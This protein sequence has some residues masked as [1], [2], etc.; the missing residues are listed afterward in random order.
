MDSVKV[1]PLNSLRFLQ[2]GIKTVISDWRM[3]QSKRRLMSR[4]RLSSLIKPNLRNPIF[5]VGA[6]RSGTTFLGSCFS[7]IPEISYHFEPILIKAASRYV[8]ED[9]WDLSTAK[10]FY[11]TVYS[12][13]M[14]LHCDADL[15]FAEKTP[16][17]SFLISFLSTTFPDAQFIHIIRD[18]RDA[19]LSY[20]KKPWLQ[21]ASAL[22]KK[23]DEAGGYP[24]GPYAR[25]WVE[26]DRIKEFETTSDI[27]RCIWAWRRHT[28]SVL[29]AASQLPAKQYHELRYEKLALNSVEEAERLLNFL[30]IF[31]SQSRCIFK[32]ATARVKAD[33]V[34]RWKHELS[35]E[36]LLSIEKEAGDLLSN[37]GYVD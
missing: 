26:S 34:G 32:Q 29:S 28:E 33:S 21:A 2:L 30:G 18:G 9:L 4:E 20:S 7:K 22:S 8:Y 15:R 37:L 24:Y 31:E 1:K 6:P 16:R 5:I 3:Y 23:Y 10:W 27:H 25:F 13:L 19:A 11:P 35:K 36:Q 14:R 12:W 17:N